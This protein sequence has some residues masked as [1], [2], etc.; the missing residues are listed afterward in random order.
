VR[1]LE[2]ED[3]RN[4]GRGAAE[5][6]S[7][8]NLVTGRN[9][10]GK[11][12]LLEAVYC[13]GGLG[14]PRSADAALVKDGAE[15]ALLHAEIRRGM[16]SLRIDLEFRPGRG[17][18]ALVNR[19]PVSGAK[20]LRELTTAVFFG[21]DDVGV[22]KGP[23]EGRRKFL[24]DAVV[25]LRPGRDV[26]RRDWDRVLRQRNTLLKTAPA[27]GRSTGFVS[28]TLAVWD[29]SFCRIG[30][31]LV[32]A[33][34]E[35]LSMLLPYVQKRFEA[36]AGEGRIE[37]SYDSSWLGAD[38]AAVVHPTTPPSASAVQRTLEAKLDDV[39]VRE[40]E[41]GVSLIGPQRDDI[42]IRL[43]SEGGQGPPVDARMYGSQGDQR[44]SALALKLGE[45]DLLTDALHEDP[46]LLLDDV[47]SE[48]D[49]RRRK[50]LI[51]SVG[52]RGQVIVSSAETAPTEVVGVARVIEIRDGHVHALE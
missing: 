8:L 30:A 28:E 15:R 51:E 14:S 36:V 19:T 48:L 29:E 12:N 26:M 24:D 1:R 35:V 27:R 18:R 44:T 13:L 49:A 42:A 5:F 32:V 46:I 3:F 50:W 47:F 41:R 23:P 52:E 9:A 4:Y 6:A 33:R 2:L 39:R 7:G 17:Q 11:T 21:P 20:A 25:K 10:Q 16:R 34:L 45:Y 40:I 38:L 43:L 22:V 37:L 31:Q